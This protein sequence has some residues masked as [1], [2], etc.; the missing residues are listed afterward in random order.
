V[1]EEFATFAVKNDLAIEIT[2]YAGDV[3]FIPSQWGHATL[4]LLETIS[5]AQEFGCLDDY[6]YKTSAR[7]NNRL[8]VLPVMQ[9]YSPI[10]QRRG[11][12]YD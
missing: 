8:L 12:S 3:L 4:N 1:T 6:I 10:F 5:V 7:N 9:I 11:G 2:Q